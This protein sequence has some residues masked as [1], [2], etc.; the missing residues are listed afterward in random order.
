MM[1]GALIG[2]M[3]I[4]LIFEMPS[5]GFQSYVVISWF[6]RKQAMKVSKELFQEDP[7]L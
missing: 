5:C 3:V 4:T 6:N 1:I 2:A 7:L